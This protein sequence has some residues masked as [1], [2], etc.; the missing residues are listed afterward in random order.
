MQQAYFDVRLRT[1][2]YSSMG[3]WRW[4]EELAQRLYYATTSQL[5][6]ERACSSAHRSSPHLC[7]IVHPHRLQTQNQCRLTKINTLMTSQHSQLA[8]PRSGPIQS[9]WVITAPGR[10]HALPALV[11]TVHRGISR[12]NTW[13]LTKNTGLRMCGR[14]GR[15]HGVADFVGMRVSRIAVDGWQGTSAARA[16]LHQR[17]ISAST[18]WSGSS[19]VTYA[20][21]SLNDEL[22]IN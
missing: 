7:N 19:T 18:V 4:S 22:S 1:H 10:G 15:F 8:P 13:Y 9:G 12:L 5:R 20:V 21:D 6:S 11:P 16:T 3:I 2:R 17:T 14:D